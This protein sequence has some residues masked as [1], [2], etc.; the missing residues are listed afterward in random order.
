[1][2]SADAPEPNA[3]CTTPFKVYPSIKVNA[4]AICET[5]PSATVKYEIMD[6]CGLSEHIDKC[7]CV[8]HWA[9]RVEYIVGAVGGMDCSLRKSTLEKPVHT[10]T[11]S[12]L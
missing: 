8:C 1:M 9:S 12:K 5:K 6:N 10:R 4:P 7:S 11:S 2:A 3:L